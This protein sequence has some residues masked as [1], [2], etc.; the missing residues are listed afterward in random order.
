MNIPRAEFSLF[1]RLEKV[2]WKYK[3][4]LK[5]EPTIYRNVMKFFYETVEEYTGRTVADMNVEDLKLAAKRC[6]IE[7]V[8]AD[9][10]VELGKSF[11]EVTMKVLYIYPDKRDQWLIRYLFKAGFLHVKRTGKD[12]NA[13][14]TK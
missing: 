4:H 2:I 13:S 14:Y 10:G 9:E 12:M 7:R 8:E 3:E 11:W 6:S 1:V 5:E